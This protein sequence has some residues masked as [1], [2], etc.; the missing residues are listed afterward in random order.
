MNKRNFRILLLSLSIC[1]GA[2]NSAAP[3][4]SSQA[5]TG[6]NR[7]SQPVPMPREKDL[8]SV[9]DLKIEKLDGETFALADFRGKVLVVDFWATDCAPCARMVPKLAEMSRQYRGQGL[10][11]V[12]LTS[13]EKSDRNLV[14]EFLKKR[15]ADYTVGFG[16]RWL[17]S[18]FLKGSEDVTGAPPIPQLFVFSRE[19]Q[20]VEH[21]I[22]DQPGR[23]V[24]YLEQVVKRHLNGAP[25]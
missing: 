11:I 17:S 8:A 16:N 21:L 1:A 7:G 14:V 15:G 5:L 25:N 12:G 23:G 22:G 9:M 10:E 19:G 3:P 20:V 24:D 6:G 4:Q 13:D 18:A 2:C